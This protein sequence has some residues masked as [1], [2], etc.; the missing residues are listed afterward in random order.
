MLLAFGMINHN[1]QKIYKEI[2]NIKKTRAHKEMI[3][4][5]FI[6]LGLY[7]RIIDGI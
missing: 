3:R 7:I 4:T 6:M 5:F 1:T 2:L